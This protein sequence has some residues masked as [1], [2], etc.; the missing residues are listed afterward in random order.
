MLSLL[1]VQAESHFVDL[2]KHVTCINKL[3]KMDNDT[4][5]LCLVGMDCWYGM[6]KPFL[7]KGFITT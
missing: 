5:F 2:E 7:Q 1:P 6:A 3:K 4:S